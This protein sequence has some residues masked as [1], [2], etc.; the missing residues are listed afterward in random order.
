MGHNGAAFGADLHSD[1]PKRDDDR[2]I[3]CHCGVV[4]VGRWVETIVGSKLVAD[5][6]TFYERAATIAL[7]MRQQPRNNGGNPP[8]I[9]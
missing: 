1:E 9:F 7:L 8:R 4:V 2:D 3:L 6:K 5:K